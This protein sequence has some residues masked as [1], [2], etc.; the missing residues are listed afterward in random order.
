MKKFG[1]GLLV[2]LLSIIFCVTVASAGG[3]E[4]YNTCP[5]CGAETNVPVYKIWI[6]DP[7]G[8]FVELDAVA[9][10]PTPF[11]NPDAGEVYT[12]PACGEEI[13]ISRT[14]V[15]VEK[16]EHE[17]SVN[18]LDNILRPALTPFD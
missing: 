6:E 14:H 11:D 5:V 12:C 3:E 7:Y 1:L 10:P 2:V 15:W 13:S 18:K 16:Q 4:V 17:G 8:N 9:D